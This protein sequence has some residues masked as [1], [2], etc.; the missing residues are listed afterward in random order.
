MGLSPWPSTPNINR[1]K[2]SGCV[3]KSCLPESEGKE[4]KSEATRPLFVVSRVMLKSS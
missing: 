1:R 4:S 2:S 3:L